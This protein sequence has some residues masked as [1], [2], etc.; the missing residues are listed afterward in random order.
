MKTIDFLMN[1]KLGFRRGQGRSID[2]G[3]L[4]MQKNLSYGQNQF[5]QFNFGGI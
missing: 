3:L 4:Y 1:L 2:G 5:G